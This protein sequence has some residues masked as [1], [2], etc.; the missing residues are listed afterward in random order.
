MTDVE[1][2]KGTP[3]IDRIVEELI[4]ALEAEAQCLMTEVANPAL[5]EL[6]GRIT[7]EGVAAMS[8]SMLSELYAWVDD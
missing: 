8:Q 5:Q 4:T 7:E 6:I 1:D 2:F 3:V